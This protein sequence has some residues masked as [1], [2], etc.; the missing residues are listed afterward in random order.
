M[1]TI[2]DFHIH[3][4]FARAT[5]RDL[6][7]NT[8]SKGSKLKGIDIL[9]TGDYGHPIWLKELKDGLSDKDDSG[10]FSHNDVNFILTTEVSTIYE[11]KIKVRKIH[12]VIHA[13][14]FEIVDQINEIT[15]KYGNLKSDGRPILTI[16]SATLVEEIM[17]VNKDILIYPAHL[18]T[19][20]FGAMGS[21]SG[22]DSLEECYQDQVKHI[23]AFETGLSS[24]P[25]MNWRLSKLDKFTQLSNSDAHSANPWRLG[26]EANVFDLKKVSYREILEAIKKKD[27]KRFLFTVEVEPSY[28]K[29]HFDGHRNCNVNLTPEQTKRLNGICPK[30]KRKLTIGVLNRVEELADRP[31]GFVPKNIIS[32][33]TLL[34]LYEIISFSVGTGKL[35][36]KKTIEENYKLINKFD[37]E[38]KVLLDVSKEDLL[39]AT[40]EK[41]VDAI[42]KVREGKVKYVPGYDGNYGYPV[43]NEKFNLETMKIPSQKSLGEF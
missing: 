40:S 22:F 15:G 41:I 8:L 31:E 4:R 5:S 19:S 20:W 2:A 39:K 11:D 24:D 10:I 26:R 25:S 32:F 28:G 6:N 7:L 17:E 3:S 16:D 33:K 34:P 29:Y 37:N 43:F 13:P 21:K 35:Y 30:C 23:H 14:S 42:M 9:G 38:F 27:N 36:S 1:R 12:H 18:W